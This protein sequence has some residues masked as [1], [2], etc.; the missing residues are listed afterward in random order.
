VRGI[1]KKEDGYRLT[2]STGEHIVARFI[3]GADGCR[4]LV[5]RTFFG[6]EPPNSILARQ[7]VLRSGTEPDTLQFRISRRYSGGY[8]WEFQYAE[9]FK[10][11]FPHGTDEIEGG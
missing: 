7:Y 11:R 10:I 9:V 1:E 2:V 6:E 5:R 3:V 8:R 4:S